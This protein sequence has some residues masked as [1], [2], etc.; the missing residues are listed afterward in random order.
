MTS[1]FDASEEVELSSTTEQTD[2]HPDDEPRTTDTRFSGTR[3]ALAKL[4]GESVEIFH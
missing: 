4:K 3:Q 2:F 1:C